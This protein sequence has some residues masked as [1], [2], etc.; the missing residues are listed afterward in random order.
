MAKVIL[1]VMISS[2][3]FVFIIG[4]K[5]FDELLRITRKLPPALRLSPEAVLIS[6]ALRLR[7]GCWARAAKG[8]VAAPLRNT[9]NSRRLIRAPD[10]NGSWGFW[11]GSPIS[12]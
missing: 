1:V 10:R 11:K 8:H 7:S 12:A 6:T 3:N 5:I 2:F 4:Q 9:M